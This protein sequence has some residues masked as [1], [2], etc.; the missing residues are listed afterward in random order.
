MRSAGPLHQCINTAATERA[1]SHR[2]P[3]G[4]PLV[5][6]LL[7]TPRTQKDVLRVPPRP[8]RTKRCSPEQPVG[9]PLMGA[10]RGPF[11]CPKKATLIRFRCQLAKATQNV[12]ITGAERPYQD[13]KDALA[14]LRVPPCPSVD[15]KQLNRLRVGEL[16]GDF[17]VRGRTRGRS[18][19]HRLP[20]R[21][22]DQW[23]CATR[24]IRARL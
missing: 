10:H 15:Q 12:T 16:A 4:A 24:P 14:V 21:R 23:V 20:L 7:W 13:T 22:W 6:A 18:R 17:Q 1:R 8:P 3:V 19:L 9:A 11:C 5:G 2:Q